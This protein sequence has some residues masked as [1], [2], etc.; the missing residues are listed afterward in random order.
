M[1][2]LLSLQSSVL[3]GYVGNET[4]ALIYPLLDIS[5]ARIDTIHLAAH[6]GH[7][8]QNAEQFSDHDIIR[9]LRSFCTLPAAKALTA[10]HSGYLATAEQ[11]LALSA[12]LPDLRK[13]SEGTISYL[14]DPVLGDSGKFYVDASIADIM[15]ENLLPKAQII[16]PNAFEL[17][18]LSGRDIHDTP[19]AIE[20]AQSL[21]DIGPDICLA[22]GIKDDDHIID[23]LTL[24]DGHSY[25]FSNP[26]EAKSVSG[27]GDCL[28]ATFFGLCLSDMD[29]V[30]AAERASTAT[31][32]IIASADDKRDMPLFAH[33][34]LFSA[35]RDA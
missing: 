28:A 26:I 24:K 22:T 1:K 4:A 30:L 29:P 7:L 20:A 18:I 25:S 15:R 12:T 34:H 3:H 6:P 14:L 16:T 5:M 33:R 21:L 35:L 10:V 11:A 27:A 31:H 2:Q 17:S 19:S 9:L 32:Q 8:T 23:I 13:S